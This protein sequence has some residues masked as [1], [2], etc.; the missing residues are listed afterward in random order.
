MT[1]ALA[2]LADTSN[3]SIGSG[4][5]S[6]STGVLGD[7]APVIFIIGGIILAVFAVNFILALVGVLYLGVRDGV[8]FRGYRNVGRSRIFHRSY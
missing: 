7:M 8:T 5:A 2:Y 1:Q 4:L 3:L 6:V